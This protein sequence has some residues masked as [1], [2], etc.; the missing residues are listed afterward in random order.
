M[1]KKSIGL[2]MR[3]RRGGAKYIAF[4]ARS[5]FGTMVTR[6]ILIDGEI[7]G[8]ATRKSDPW[9]YAHLVE[10]GHFVVTPKKNT[11]IRKGNAVLASGKSFVAARPFLRPAMI[12]SKA[13]VKRR[14]IESINQQLARFFAKVSKQALGRVA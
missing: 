3:G 8:A 2:L 13:E 6:P 10:F 7:V 1:L 14:L 9:F 5:G 4:G 11:S 12:G